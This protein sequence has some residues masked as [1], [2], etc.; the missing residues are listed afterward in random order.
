MKHWPDWI[1][2]S[3]FV[4]LGFLYL[5]L[6]VLILS[7][8]NDSG[9]LTEWDGLSLKWYGQ[10]LADP[11]II[12]AVRTSLGIAAASATTSVIL[13]TLAGLSLTRISSSRGRRVFAALVVLPLVMPEVI[14]GLLLVFLF[15][16]LGRLIGLPGL[17]GAVTIS[18]AHATVGMAYVTVFVAARLAGNANILEEAAKDLGATPFRAFTG[19]SLPIIAPAML[20]G[21]L[22]AFSLS[23]DDVVIASFVTGPDTVTLPMVIY[24]RINAGAYGEANAIGAM[25]IVIIAAIALVAWA[26]M[27]LALSRRGAGQGFPWQDR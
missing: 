16:G 7:S 13:G 19:V 27:R 23:F 10:L 17:L 5:P 22:L 11:E 21:W 12:G 3:L 2:V 4:G 14:T 8:F 9:L 1:G 26:M 24:S 25:L 6:L 18:I 15:T 20:V